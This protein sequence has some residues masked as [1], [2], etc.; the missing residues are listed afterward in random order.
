VQEH[1]RPHGSVIQ[2]KVRVPVVPDTFVDRPRLRG[3][4]ARL[5]AE[6]RITV[7]SATAG[8]GKTTAVVSATETLGYPVAWLSVDRT[9]AAPGRLVTYL[10]AALTQRLPGLA[11]VAT[12]ALAAGI[13]HAEAAGFLAEGVGENRILLVL[14]NL[15]RLG[16][17]REAWAVVEA[18]LRY[19]PPALGIVLV[20][21]REIPTGICALPVGGAVA[22]LGESELALTTAEAGEALARVGKADIDAASA[23]R[24]TGGWLTGVLFEAWRSADHVVGG[25]GE[26]DPLYGYLS[27]QILDEL[28]PADRE[29]LVA[30]ALLDE[31][32]APRAAALGLRR[33]GE[34]LLALRAAHL[35]VSWERDGQVM[36]CH[37]RF[38][39]YLSERLERL[40]EDELHGLRIAH[41][42]Q[43]A[44]EDLQEDAT[45]EFLRAG[46]HGYAGV[47]AE[48]AI[49]DVVER[50]D[51]AIAERWTRELV[52]SSPTGASNLT[53]AEL[54][55]AVA[56]D[57]FRRVV[58]IGDRV[59]AAGERD[60]LVSS[61]ETAVWTLIW[62]YITTVRPDDVRAVLA[63]ARP[64]PVTDAVRYASQV[65]IDVPGGPVGRPPLTGRPVDALIYVADYSLGNLDEL[66]NEPGSRYAELVRAQWRVAAL[67]AMGY[68]KQALDLLASTPPTSDR[69]SLQAW[70][71]PLV[72]ID[73]GRGDDAR[74]QLE[75]GR[76][77]ARE[78]GQIAVETMNGLAQAKLAL[79]VDGDPGAA[80]AVLDQPEHRRV[81]AAFTS[82]GEY[83]DMWYGLAL[84]RESRDAQAL[85]RLRRSVQ[86][87]L[88][89]GR[90]LELPIA[91]VYLAEGEWRAGDGDA[92][93]AAADVALDAARRQGSNHHLL[94]ALADFPAVASRRIDAEAGADSRWHEIGRALRAQG[95]ELTVEIGASVEL[96]EFG[97]RTILLD[98]QEVR[99]RIHKAYE[100]LALLA[101]R[102]PDP[103]SRDELLAALFGA[104]N[105]DSARS[106]LR[107]AVHWLRH[108]LPA[109]GV[110]VEAGSVRLSGQL[111]VVSES[112]RFE[113]ELAQAARLQNGER[114]S[115]TLA[116]LA[117]YDRGEYLPGRRSE[118]TDARERALSSV[119]ADARFEAAELALA[120]GDY[121]RARLL[122]E[123]V[124]G[125]E[126]FHEAG[127]RLMM[128]IANM[129]GDENAVIRAFHECERSLAS[130]GAQPAPSTRELLTH[131]R[132]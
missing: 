46:A 78:Q 108:A 25:G 117:M 130:V 124:V 21:R 112:K 126:P 111:V 13:P 103:V 43:L 17:T 94:Q 58:E 86:G 110:I 87:M 123:Q 101:T 24:A 22:V 67:R 16:E 42:R 18:L 33:S 34:R 99:P 1:Q 14:D 8:A 4:L 49:M 100:L 70:I 56:H 75:L 54:M 115:A 69:L 105:T 107:Q 97:A 73:A 116:A 32:S 132:R 9:D 26:A 57:D 104:S 113:S 64:G 109:G 118:W 60:L 7:V 68:T 51:F 79:R 83:A 98:G 62:G 52:H 114:L 61:S 36:R 10:E 81:A 91:A 63:A 39:E 93:D 37:P 40:D 90:I 127:W 85:T 50:G 29:F 131:L 77:L 3:L 47:T 120:A 11:G 19:A 82:I 23:V 12:E 128:R 44:A 92:A 6:R 55:L 71:G 38:R 89:G 95:V 20:S 74:A 80:R 15:E 102:Q 28:D 53:A 2:S 66:A 84:L 59:A 119:A 5:I 41:A 45:E 31:V 106:Y 65:M 72:L 96:L 76:R 30:T 121:T 129:L 35:P 48:R 27:S 122:A 125:A 88:R